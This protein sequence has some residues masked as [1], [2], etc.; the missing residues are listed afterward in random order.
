VPKLFKIL[1]YFTLLK[2]VFLSFPLLAADCSINYDQDTTISADCDGFTL[3]RNLDFD[4]TIITGVTVSA[5][6]GS[7]N[8]VIELNFDV[9]GVLTNNG[10]IETT[11]GDRAIDISYTPATVNAIINTGNITAHRDTIN[12]GPGSTLNLLSNAGT[13]YSTDSKSIYNQGSINSINNSG[14]IQSNSGAIYNIDTLSSLTNTNLITASTNAIDNG[15]TLGTITNSG[16]ISASLG[17]A[18]YNVYGNIESITN[19]STGDINSASDTIFNGPGRYISSLVNQ[20]DIDASADAAIL[21]NGTISSLTNSGTIMSPEGIAIE[22]DGAGGA[23][24][25][26]TNSGAIT[27]GTGISNTTGSIET[28]TN[29]GS[30]SSL[31]SLADIHNNGNINMLINRQRNL[32]FTGNLPANYQIMIASTSNYGKIRFTDVN[33]TTIFDIHATSSVNK[34]TTYTDVITGISDAELSAT[35][36]TFTDAEGG[37]YDWSLNLDGGN[38]DLILGDCTGTC[39]EEETPEEETPEEET[40]EEETPEEETPEVNYPSNSSTQSSVNNIAS[41]INAQFSSFAMTTNFANLNTYDCGLFDKNNGCF[42]VGGRYTEVNGNNNSDSDSSALVM[43]GGYRVEDTF[44]IAGF[45]DQMVNNSTPTGIKVENHNPMV[46]VSFIL[47]QNA[48]H[49]GYQFKL[50]NAYQTKDV[51]ITRTA[52]GDAEAGS[53]STDVTVNSIIAEA[54]YQFLSQNRTSYR[55]YFAGRYAKIKQDGYTETNVDNGLTYQDLEDESITL[56]MGLKTKHFM[57]EKFILNGTVGVEQDI[58]NDSDNLVATATNIA[59]ITAVDVNSDDNKTRPVVSLGA[60]YFFTP[61]Q[62]LSFQAQYQELAY[63][64][65]SAKTA[66]VSYTIGF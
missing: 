41:S 2:G 36:G 22:N 42:S 49:L 59:G 44:R 6:L 34:N 31:T 50:A 40:P 16:T 37:S 14:Q 56:I 32:T 9:G 47:N 35:T 11:Y 1:I 55:P 29:T 46:G 3:D 4:M 10:T 64:S 23:I 38:Y 19:T 54:S 39:D 8:N 25:N 26:L 18:I 12:I 62:R 27:G 28:I 45:V 15:G 20:G 65:T 17:Y 24:T 51:T 7:E 43:V 58:Y 57:N 52:T 53:G 5:V 48:D 63:T 61:T 33:G 60:D 66:Y 21:N 30:I 13:I